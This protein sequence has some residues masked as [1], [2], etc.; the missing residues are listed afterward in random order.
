MFL[1]LDVIAC[2]DKA[3]Q[4]SKENCRLVCI[5]MCDEAVFLR[6]NNCY[7]ILSVWSSIQEVLQMEALELLTNMEL[8]D[9]HLMAVSTDSQKYNSTCIVYNK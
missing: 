3:S 4:V 9:K 5:L 8:K 7:E 2:S 1:N 6:Q